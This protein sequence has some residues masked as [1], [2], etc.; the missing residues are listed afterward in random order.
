MITALL[1]INFV[2]NVL[3]VTFL[4]LVFIRVLNNSTKEMKNKKKMTK[5]QIKKSEQQ[6]QDYRRKEC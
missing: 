4:C 1:Y 2:F 5:E 6:K 3:F